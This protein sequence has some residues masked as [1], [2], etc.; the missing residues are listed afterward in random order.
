MNKT[1]WLNKCSLCKHS[2]EPKD[3]DKIKWKIVRKTWEIIDKYKWFSR[4]KITVDWE[5]KEIYFEDKNFRVD[6]TNWEIKKIYWVTKAK[7]NPHWDIIEYIDWKLSWE[8]LFTYKAMK[9]ELSLHSWRIPTSNN[10]ELQAIISKIWI[11]KITN[12]LPGMFNYH[13]DSHQETNALLF[14]TDI[15]DWTTN[16]CSNVL[17]NWTDKW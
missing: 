16:I 7:I 17:F 1:K 3:A 6:S 14:W 13:C 10:W 11:D 12:K 8:Q 5:T 2:F 15:S 9:R 4:I